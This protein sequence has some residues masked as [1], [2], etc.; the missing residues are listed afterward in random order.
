VEYNKDFLLYLLKIIFKVNK[1]FTTFHSTQFLCH[2]YHMIS[3][4]THW[5]REWQ[6]TWRVSDWC[7]Q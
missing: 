5:L 4:S 7:S 1:L 3:L 2:F 6:R